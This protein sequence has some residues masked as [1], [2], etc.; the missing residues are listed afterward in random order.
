MG[1]KPPLTVAAFLL[2][3]A[4]TVAYT[5]A[6]A[7]DAPVLTLPGIQI[8]GSRENERALVGSGTYLD[9]SDIR[10]QNY[11][12]INRVLRKAPGVYIREEDGF[13]IFPNISLRGVDHGRSA[14]V[15]LLED[16]IPMAPAPYASPAAYYSPTAGRM[17]GIEVL[18]GSSQVRFGPHVTGG[19]V[20]YLSTPI[21]QERETYTRL[22]FGTDNDLRVHA[23]TGDTI[24]TE[25]GRFGYLLEGY[26]RENDGFKTIDPAAGFPGSNDTG[27]SNRDY[28]VKLSYEPNGERYQRFEFSL[29]RTDLDADETYVGLTEADFANDPFRRY[30]GTRFDNIETEQTRVA[31]RHYIDLTPR[32]NLSTVAYYNEFARNWFKLHRVRENGGSNTNPANAIAEGGAILDV[33]KGTGPGVLRVR[34]NARDYYS[35]GI[36]S[37]LNTRFDTAGVAHD[38]TASFRIHRDQIDRFQQEEE[39]QQDANGAIIGRTLLAD[40]AAGDRIQEATAYSISIDDRMDFGRLTLAPGVRYEYVDLEYEQDQRRADNG[41]S[42]ARES[43][44]IDLWGG[45]IGALWEQNAN[46]S[47]N[48]GVFFGYSPPGPRAILRGGLSEERSVAYE[49]GTSYVSTSGAF[50]AKATQFRTDFD[51]LVVVDNAGASAGGSGETTSVGEVRTQGVE[52]GITYDPA[53]DMGLSYGLPMFLA[54]TY[55]DATIQN[56]S[57][58]GD[59]E[60]IFSGGADGNDVPYIPDVQ[61][62]FGAGYEGR[63]WGVNAVATYVDSSFGSASNTSRQI[64]PNG[65]P[66]ARYGKIDSFFTVDFSGYYELR[67]GVKIVGGVQNAFDE[68]YL[69]SRL[70]LGPRPGKPRTFYA[71]LEAK[72]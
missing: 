63:Q 27:L 70:P 46:L 38:L 11:D 49:L 45:G 44:S 19:V 36:K 55:T 1:F 39:F 72:F 68:E 66:D 20:N 37:T 15:M 23:Y 21:P 8:I 6:A 71:G 42:P 53:I 32:T 12:D 9:T 25:A 35:T 59:A 28:N 26:A 54:A 14:K 34:N 22:T 3:T 65:N 5:P 40:G 29:G 50:E 64:D 67:E 2:G 16:G 24:E 52:L 57:T 31:L 43:G 69:S 18:K 58:S 41:G 17:S 48:G 4:A 47:F 61:I 33:I 62:T 7:Q 13:G 30:A 10:D 51:D 56:A 60:S